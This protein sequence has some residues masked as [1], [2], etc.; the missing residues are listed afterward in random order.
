MLSLVGMAVAHSRSRDGDMISLCDVGSLDAD[1]FVSEMSE[2][3]FSELMIHVYECLA[4]HSDTLSLAEG[5]LVR[6]A[7]VLDFERL[8]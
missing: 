6:H 8:G 2:D 7:L 3:E 5:R 4:F 1:G